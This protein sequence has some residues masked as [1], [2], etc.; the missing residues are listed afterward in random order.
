M[1]ISSQLMHT[2]LKLASAPRIQFFLL[3]QQYS[4]SLAKLRSSRPLPDPRQ[5]EQYRKLEE[6]IKRALGQEM[7]KNKICGC[8]YKQEVVRQVI[9]GNNGATRMR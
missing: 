3:T 7:Y 5:H 4:R 1:T 2:F 6:A 8:L 9:D